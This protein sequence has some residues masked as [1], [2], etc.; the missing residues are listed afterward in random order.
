MTYRAY[1]NKEVENG[2]HIL[3]LV[4]GIEHC[5]RDIADTLSNNPD[6]GCCADRIKQ[7]L[8]GHQYRQAH[9]NETKRL[10]VGVLL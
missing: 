6:D 3:F 8:K 1:K 10:D 9:T 7:R 2:M 5:T 4:K